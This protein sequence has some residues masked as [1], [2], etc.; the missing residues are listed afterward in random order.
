MI[1]SSET[2]AFVLGEAILD[3]LMQSSVEVT[4]SA[5]AYVIRHHAIHAELIGGD[6]CCIGWLAQVRAAV[7]AAE[8][9]LG[10][11]IMRELTTDDR[12]AAILAEVTALLDDETQARRAA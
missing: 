1:P 5:L 2:P 9:K 10:D 7:D 4:A 12:R 11:Y 6:D 3:L 8:D